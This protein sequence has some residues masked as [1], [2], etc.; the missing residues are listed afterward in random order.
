MTPYKRTE[1]TVETDQVTIIR[2]RR[3]M[4]AW[5]R[6]C[7]CEV[8][9]VGLAEAEALTGMDGPGL[10]IYAEARGWHLFQGEDGSDLICLES[11]LKSA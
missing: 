9:M 2:R 11:W 4:R 8:D 6:Q 3:T 1:I 5:C 10:R 7:G